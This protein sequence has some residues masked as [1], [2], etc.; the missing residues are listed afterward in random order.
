M[1]GPY[2]EVTVSKVVYWELSIAKARAMLD[3][4]PTRDVFQMI[5]EDWAMKS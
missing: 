4:N 5:D 3:Y 1:G 2:V